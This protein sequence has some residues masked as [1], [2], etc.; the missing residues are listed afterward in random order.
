MSDYAQTVV[1]TEALPRLQELAPGVIIEMIPI[2]GGSADEIDTGELDLALG[3]ARYL[4]T[5]HPSERLYE[6]EFVCL[7]WS[8]N[9]QLDGAL[10]LDTYLDSDTSLSG[11]ENSENCPL[12]TSGSHSIW[13]TTEESRWLPPLSISFRNCS[14]A[15]RELRQS[16]G[17]SRHSISDFC[18]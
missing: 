4:V 10:S 9:R 13:D 6:D 14:L 1:M 8:G 5:G 7:G 11:S 3:P 15:L 2:I 12:S 18:H 16:M 17:G